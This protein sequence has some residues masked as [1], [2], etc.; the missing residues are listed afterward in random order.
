M[1]NMQE[2][3]EKKNTQTMQSSNLKEP[4]ANGSSGNSEIKK[5]LES[6]IVS[7]SLHEE[8]KRSRPEYE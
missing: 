2:T 1:R 6:L 8:R 5:L 3:S 4:S 7:K